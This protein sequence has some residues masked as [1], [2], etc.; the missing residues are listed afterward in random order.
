MLTIKL[1]NCTAENNRVDKTNFLT[2]VETITGTL[3]ESTSILDCDIEIE[4]NKFPDFNY[5]YIQEFNRYYFVEDIISIVNNLW[6]VSLSVDVLMSF[7]DNLLECR[8]FIDR[9]E[10]YYAPYSIDTERVIRQGSNN[11]SIE[12]TTVTAG[13]P[14]I[15]LNNVG[16]KS[17]FCIVLNGYNV[18]AK[19]MT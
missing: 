10:K 4:Y 12:M 15:V 9:N 6:S 17:E 11:E 8:A 5:I 19:E 14:N 3:R 1:Y 2:L 18:S 7:K 16:S 13:Y